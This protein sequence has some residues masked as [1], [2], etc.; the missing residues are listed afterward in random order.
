MTKTA[1]QIDLVYV[2]DEQETMRIHAILSNG[3]LASPEMYCHLYEWN[4]EDKRE[5]QPGLLTDEDGEFRKYVGEWGIG[6]DSDV[7]FEFL[8][9]PL[10]VGQQVTRTDVVANERHV[11]TY[12]IKSIVDLLSD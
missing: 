4:K 2:E 12:E 11:Y 8:D 7:T 1:V 10:A 3:K 5:L 6:D 9:R